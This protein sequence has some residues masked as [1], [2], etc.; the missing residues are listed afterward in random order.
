MA[1]KSNT[2][3]VEIDGPQNQNLY[4]RPLMRAVRGRF[5]LHR[6]REPN[7]G[8]LHSVWPEPI[9]GQRLELDLVSGEGA[10][11]EPLHEERYSAI[12][13]KIESSGQKIAPEREVFE[14]RDLVTWVYWMQ[15]LVTSGKAKL[16][17]GEFPKL[18]GKPR[19]RFHSTEHP[20]PIDKLTAAI[21]RQNEL[22][23]KQIEIMAKLVNQVV[24]EKQD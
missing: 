13:E 24:N 7:A 23:S 1:T 16:V 4:F 22:N 3:A 9:P 17:K 15:G 18:S 12:R 14:Q 6:V 21:E 10:I 2:L 19:T 11:V 5:D 20:D 8:R